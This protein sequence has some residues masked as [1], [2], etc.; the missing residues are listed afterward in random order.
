MQL[1]VPDAEDISFVILKKIRQIL[2]GESGAVYGSIDSIPH[3]KK[4]NNER[5][6]FSQV[7]P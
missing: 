4:S 7:S 6:F 2:G 5:V 1:D 3:V